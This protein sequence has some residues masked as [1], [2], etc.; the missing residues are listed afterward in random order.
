MF[1]FFSLPEGPLCD[2]QILPTNGGLHIRNTVQK[3]FAANDIQLMLVTT[4]SVKK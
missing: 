1:S 4:P 2:S 3:C